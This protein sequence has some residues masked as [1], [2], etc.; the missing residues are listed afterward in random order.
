MI[1]PFSNAVM[2][3]TLAAGLRRGG[4][5]VTYKDIRHATDLVWWIDK[6]PELSRLCGFQIRPH[7]RDP[8]I[9][10]INAN[11]PEKWVNGSL[12]QPWFLGNAIEESGVEELVFATYEL[13]N[14]CVV[15]EL[16]RFCAKQVRGITASMRSFH[17]TEVNFPRFAMS[18]SARQELGE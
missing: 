14:A 9:I 12:L 4:A 18:I 7:H 1:N 11:R 2:R 15:W 16:G 6:S 5:N 17:A 13:E 8:E 10:I 3:K